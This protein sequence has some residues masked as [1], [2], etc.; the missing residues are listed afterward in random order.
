[1]YVESRRTGS[2]VAILR[3]PSLRDLQKV[4]VVCQHGYDTLN[5]PKAYEA[6]P[7]CY[8]VLLFCSY[9]VAVTLQCQG[10][11]WICDE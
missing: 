11:G 7:A 1:V 5:L 3:A 6:V 2:G 8:V 10:A 9:G 4:N